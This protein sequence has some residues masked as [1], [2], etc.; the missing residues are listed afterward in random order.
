MIL[1]L[2]CIDPGATTGIAELVVPT[3]GPA[4]L[5]NSCEIPGT[6]AA[7]AQQFLDWHR[8]CG[9]TDLR[10]TQ[11]IVIETWEYRHNQPTDA[12]M[13]C[14]PI[15]MVKMLAFIHR[16]PITAEQKPGFRSSIPDTKSELKPLGY[17]I[18]GEGH[19]RQALRHGLAYLIRTA[20]H[21]PTMEYLFPRPKD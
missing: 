11:L 1:N 17:W 8:S 3:I 5:R 9:L 16:V 10:Y 12:R 2:L 13:A 7:L 6:P 21:L 4:I 19:A 14:E 15:G 20:H 18:G